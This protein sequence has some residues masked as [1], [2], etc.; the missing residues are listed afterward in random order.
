MLPL[1]DGWLDAETPERRVGAFGLKSFLDLPMLYVND[2][3]GTRHNKHRNW[4]KLSWKEMDL[5]V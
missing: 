3:T 2:N 5:H 4:A 1:I